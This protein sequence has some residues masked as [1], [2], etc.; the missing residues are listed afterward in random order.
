MVA[1]LRRWLIWRQ[2]K[3]AAAVFVTQIAFWLQIC[4]MLAYQ[5]MPDDC[6]KQ[7]LQKLLV[8]CTT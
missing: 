4:G 5:S 3:R 2:M 7:V 8:L 6:L 1:L